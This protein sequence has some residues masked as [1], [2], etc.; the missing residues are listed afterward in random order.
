MAI[1]RFEDVREFYATTLGLPVVF[2]EADHPG[3]DV[4]RYPDEF[5]LTL[6]FSAR[7]WR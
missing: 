4:S 3:Q 7:H 2:E 1:D 5:K 6:G